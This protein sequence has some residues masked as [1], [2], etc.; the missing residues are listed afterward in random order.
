MNLQILKNEEKQMNLIM[1]GVWGFLIPIAACVFVMLFLKGTILDTS[2][3]L[4]LVLAVLIRVFEKKLDFRAKYL[5]ACLMPVYGA[6]T[7]IVSND[8]KFGA[9][10]H[11]YFLATIMVIAYYDVSVVKVNIAVTMAVNIIAMIIFPGAY[12][13]LHNLI[14]WIFIWIV[15]AL[16]AITAFLISGRTYNLF[17]DVEKKEDEVE[18]ILKKVS[19][20]TENLSGA[21]TLLVETSQTESAS[22][23]EL[24]AISE[25][26]LESNG[27][28]LD[29]AEQSK[30]NLASLEES[31]EHMEHKMSDVDLISKELV[32]ISVSNEQALNN[33]MSM[34]EEV[35]RSTSKTREVTDKLLKESGEIGKTL[36][37]INEIAESI[38]LLALNA[39]I[40]AARAGEAGKGFAVVA[41]EVGH[42]AENTKES[43]KNV[44]YVVSRVQ[45]GTTDV[46]KFM[47]ENAEQLL[48]QNK[49]IVET[50]HGIRNMMELLKKSLGVITEANEI[51][52][53]QNSV[54]QETVKI[55]ED[56]AERINQENKEFS[57]IT[58]MVQGNTKEIMVLM[59]QVD[60]I[61]S[62]IKE[63]EGLMEA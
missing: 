22:T 10:T 49:V 50:V 15:Y 39:S 11:V 14:V 6:F 27:T 23:E 61:N 54:I 42:L 20:I 51:R 60:T 37:I 2:I 52:E 35:E 7:L 21:S 4:G 44:N 29:K 28:M 16:C 63:L 45:S 56:I 17:V 5:Y 30:E 47:N 8:G 32:D 38:N 19:G 59:E 53:M 36:D 58:S 43:L 40:E 46:S 57:N 25:N 1:F 18:N 24:S 33:L 62:M 3:L 31:C 48:N 13:K 9:M 41:Q 34:S 55:N 26:L 12:L